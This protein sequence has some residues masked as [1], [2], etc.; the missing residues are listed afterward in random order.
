MY[1]YIYIHLSGGVTT[2]PSIPAR[3]FPTS[4]GLGGSQQQQSYM[5]SVCGAVSSG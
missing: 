2:P 4:C 1:I 3:L 5:G